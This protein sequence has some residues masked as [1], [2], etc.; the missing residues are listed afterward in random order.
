MVYPI[1]LYGNPILREISLDIPL[2][3][4]VS[5][6]IN[7]IQKT[8]NNCSFGVGLAANQININSQIFIVN[9]NYENYIFNQVFIN[10]NIILK[11]KEANIFEEGCL[12]LPNITENIERSNL[13]RIEFYDE[14][15]NYHRKD[16][17]GLESR[18]IQHEYDHTNGKMF[19]DHLIPIKKRIINNQLNQI[20]KNKFDV[21]YKTN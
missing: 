6:I 20:I 16:Y 15:W 7:K 10:P 21:N 8:L 5:N 4:N 1:V 3:S 17:K 12:S 13:I 18:I 2:Y 9:I 11:S 19:V 14:N